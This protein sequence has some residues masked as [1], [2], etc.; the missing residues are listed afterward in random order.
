MYVSLKAVD[1]D[2]FER[3][4]PNDQ[5]ISVEEALEDLRGISGVEPEETEWVIITQNDDE[6]EIHTAMVHVRLSGARGW[7]IIRHALEDLQTTSR[8]TAIACEGEDDEHARICNR[9]SI[10]ADQLLSKLPKKPDG[11]EY[12]HPVEP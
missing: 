8:E 9:T 6:R 3:H 10:D 5:N 2:V 4:Y 1:G 7:G 11:G 12:P